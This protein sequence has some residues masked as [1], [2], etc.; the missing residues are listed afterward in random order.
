MVLYLS[1][2]PAPAGLFSRERKI[3]Q[4]PVFDSRF[5]SDLW[6]VFTLGVFALIRLQVTYMCVRLIQICKSNIVWRLLASGMI[7]IML[8]FRVNTLHIACKISCITFFLISF[9]LLACV[10]RVSFDS[11]QNEIHWLQ[12]DYRLGKF[13]MNASNGRT[14]PTCTCLIISKTTER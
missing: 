10:R 4:Q 1:S 6:K 11:T 14:D 8:I 3:W 12:K 7:F 9:D 5:P 2:S 13:H